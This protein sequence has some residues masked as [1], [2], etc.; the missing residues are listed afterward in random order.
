MSFLSYL[1]RLQKNDLNTTSRFVIQGS[2]LNNPLVSFLFVVI[3]LRCDVILLSQMS[4]SLYQTTSKR[5]LLEPSTE[6]VMSSTP[7]W[8]GGK[9]ILDNDR[10]HI[11]SLRLAELPALAEF[12]MNNHEGKI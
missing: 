4:L 3:Y 9:V 11:V 8:V 10:V 5:V 2:T 1:Y 6:S 7:S 12:Y